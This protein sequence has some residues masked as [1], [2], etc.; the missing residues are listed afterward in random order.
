V[1]SSPTEEVARCGANLT[2]AGNLRNWSFEEFRAVFAT[3]RTPEGKQLDPTIMP[4]D[5]IGKAQPH[6]IEAIWTYLRSVPAKE[7]AVVH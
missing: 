3:G 1:G 7:G 2:P 5:A 6:E 4:W